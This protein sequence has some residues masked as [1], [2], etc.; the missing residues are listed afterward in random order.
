MF[1]LVGMQNAFELATFFWY[2][3]S[4]PAWPLSDSGSS[5]FDVKMLIFDLVRDFVAVDV[6]IQLVLVG[7]EQ[8]DGLRSPVSRVRLHQ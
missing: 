8:M 6:R 7:E 4:S 3:V 5:N 2:L 1:D